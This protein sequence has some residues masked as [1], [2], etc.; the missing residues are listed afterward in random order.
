MSTMPEIVFESVWDTFPHLRCEVRFGR[1]TISKAK[2]NRL[3]EGKIVT[4]MGVALGTTTIVDLR[5]AD[6]PL[7]DQHGGGWRP[8]DILDVRLIGDKLWKQYRV[9]GVNGNGG[10][11][12][13]ELEA[14]SE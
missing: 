13:L 3:D 5:Q 2:L 4:D 6:S 12:R 1:H 11:I 10:I 14:E 8:G 7:P 9:A